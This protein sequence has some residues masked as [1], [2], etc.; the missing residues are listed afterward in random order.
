MQSRANIALISYLKFLRALRKGQDMV[1]GEA[2]VLAER[3]KF[4]GTE[5]ILEVWP[6]MM[7][8]W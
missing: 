4:A 2:Q 6:K 1:P 5:V 7:H 8:I 3:M